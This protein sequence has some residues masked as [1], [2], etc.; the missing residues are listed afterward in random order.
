MAEDG[1][2]WVV[3]WDLPANDARLRRR[4]YRRLR[5]IIKEYMEGKKPTLEEA[6]DVGLFIWA[7]QSV[8]VTDI[9][10]LAREIYEL[11]ASMARRAMIMRG[12][13]PRI[14]GSD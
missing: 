13:H 2:V 9:E 3:A 7:Q 8:I 5:S 4:F 12:E 11:A 1:R 14:V 6:E 10:K